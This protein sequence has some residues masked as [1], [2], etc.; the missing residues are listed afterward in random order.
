M[1]IKNLKIYIRN[2]SGGNLNIGSISLLSGESLCIWD[3]V[4]Y[5]AG[6]I[7][8]IQQ[9]I[10]NIDVFNESVGNSDL[11]MVTNGED[12]TSDQA[13][14]QFS[15]LHRSYNNYELDSDNFAV[16]KQKEESV[17]GLVGN[18]SDPQI[19]KILGDD[20][21]I[22]VKNEINFI[23][24]SNVTLGFDGD[25]YTV[26]VI[27]NASGEG[28]GG[29]TGDVSGPSTTTTNNAIVRWDGTDG[30]TIQDSDVIIDDGNNVSGINKI[31]IAHIMGPGILTDSVDGLSG[32][33]DDKLTV[34]S[35]IIK[36]VS[37][38]SMDLVSEYIINEASSGQSPTTIYDSRPTPQ[39]LTIA[40]NGSYP[41]FEE[42]SSGRGIRLNPGILNCG[43]KTGDLGSGKIRTTLNGVQKLTFEFVIDWA[44]T[45]ANAQFIFGIGSFGSMGT[46]AVVSPSTSLMSI[47]FNSTTDTETYFSIVTGFSI[48]HIVYDTTQATASDRIKL[49]RNGSQVSSTSGTFPD[50]NA[51]LDIGFYDALVLGRTASDTNTRSFNGAIYYASIWEGAMSQVEVSVRYNELLVNN[52]QESSGLANKN[53][54]LLFS[55][56]TPIDFN[57]Q[58]IIDAKTVTFEAWPTVNATGSAATVEFDESQGATVN[59][60]DQ[61]SVTITL[62]EPVGPGVFELLVKQGTTT[63]TT[64]FTWATEGTHA[65]YSISG[66]ITIASGASSITLLRL[67][68]DGTDWYVNSLQPMQQ[69]IAS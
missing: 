10:D 4:D 9:I 35:P 17:T 41:Y 13:F 60:N 26:D 31:T 42:I 64:S 39:N 19:I 20:A 14:E 33:L 5:T 18:L 23:G 36:T 68:Y 56:T 2:D 24:G 59:L 6:V 69:V 65:I 46:G 40:Y 43:A 54:T 51:T 28:G 3:T 52:D 67:I 12:K 11:V 50:L 32:Y 53:V 29:G 16:L 57:N 44:G 63:E 58:N 30:Y 61:A 21:E 45:N 38:P 48:Y 7:D 62:N 66:S 1:S 37:E 15:Q 8:N 49:Y 47:A 34:V 22:G 55:P 27:I 25:G